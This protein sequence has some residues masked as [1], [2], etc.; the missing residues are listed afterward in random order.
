[1]VLW[2]SESE[3]WSKWP[4]E[5]KNRPE[6]KSPDAV[7]IIG[8]DNIL[9]RE[10]VFSEGHFDHFYYSDGHETIHHSKGN[11]M[12]YPLVIFFN[13]LA[14]SIQ[15]KCPIKRLL[16]TFLLVDFV[17]KAIS[18]ISMARMVIKV[19]IIRK[20]IEGSL[21]WLLFIAIAGIVREISEFEM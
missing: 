2:P 12:S 13:F 1:M 20:R 3:K 21:I 11:W 16:K 10:R 4:S 7:F 6:I 18:T 14:L 15:T 17:R 9:G 8:P 5:K 19:H